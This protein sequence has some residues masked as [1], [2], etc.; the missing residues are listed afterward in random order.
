MTA[1]AEV[2]DAEE[3]IGEDGAAPA[4]KKGFSLP[5]LSK[6]LLIII[7]AALIVVLSG[8]AALYSSVL[9]KPAPVEDAAAH[10]EAPPESFIFNLP[11]MTVNLRNEGDEADQFMKLTVAIEVADEGV[12]REIEPRM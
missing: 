8:A 11:P 4:K 7:A 2:A 6:K 5:K 10:V 9:A 3:E 1:E 12:M